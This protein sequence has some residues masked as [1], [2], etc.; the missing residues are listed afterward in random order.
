MDFKTKKMNNKLT[1]NT[2]DYK[3]KKTIITGGLGF[4]GSS[5]ARKLVGLGA[6]VTIIDS[7]IPGCG[8]NLHNIAGIEKKVKVNISDVRDKYSMNYLVRNQEIMF[9]LAGTL[10]HVDSMTDPFS[11]LEINCVSQLSILEAC[12]H[13]N[14][15]IKIIWAGTRNQYGRAQY[16]PVDENHPQIPTDVNGI[17]NI[18]GEQY[19]L[20]YYHV[21][22]IKTVSLRLTN[23]YGPR[24]QMRHSRQ[25]VLNWFIRQIIDGEEIKLMGSGNQIRDVNYVD[26][27]SDAFLI[28][29]LSD[30]VW[31]EAYNLG[32]NPITLEDFVKRAIN[33][34]GKGSYSYIP[35]T[36]DRKK[37]EIGNYIANWRKIKKQVGW[38]PK[39]TLEKGLEE[40]F[41]YYRI[42]KNHYW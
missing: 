16:S 11:D 13:N 23:C 12:R 18:A 41:N 19:H 27:V 1:A 20:L 4:L 35:F 34:Y 40:T 33:V 2:N 32:G 3:N 26:D 36:N 15:Q 28:I 25:G 38:K 10:S 5:L 29:G 6:K 14:P 17:N 21:Y 8:G 37:I 39:V 9:N 30:N 7:L 31:G 22:G 42:H 24:H